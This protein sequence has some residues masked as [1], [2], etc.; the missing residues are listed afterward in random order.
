MYKRCIN[1]LIILLSTLNPCFILAIYN[2]KGLSL[3]LLISLTIVKSLL[4]PDV[5]SPIKVTRSN[6][7]KQSHYTFTFTV[8]ESISEDATVTA[9]FPAQFSSGL[10]IVNCLGFN[11]RGGLI[12]NDSLHCLREIDNLAGSVDFKRYPFIRGKKCDESHCIWRH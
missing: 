2:M 6:M 11:L 8:E 12:R 9:Q 1:T 5:R 4:I 3:V 7:G 10:G